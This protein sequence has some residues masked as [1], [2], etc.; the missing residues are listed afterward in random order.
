MRLGGLYDER[1]GAE[2]S[3]ALIPVIKGEIDTINMTD[4]EHIER[5]ALA[6]FVPLI[7]W[8]KHFQEERRSGEK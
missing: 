8:P 5:V 2:L 3:D 1:R 7:K 6:S 4:V